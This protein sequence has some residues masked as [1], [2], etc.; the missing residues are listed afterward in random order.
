[1]DS[2]TSLQNFRGAHIDPQGI[3]CRFDDVGL[4]AWVRDPGG[5]GDVHLSLPDRKRL[6]AEYLRWCADGLV[7]AL[8]DRPLQLALHELTKPEHRAP[9]RHLLAAADMPVC[10]SR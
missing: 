2:V 4:I 9:L 5:A 8:E 3:E 6:G 1:M 10:A 7:A